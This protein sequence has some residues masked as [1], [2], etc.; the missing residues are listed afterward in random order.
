MYAT[1]PYDYKHNLFIYY[2]L[3]NL[4]SSGGGLRTCG[5]SRTS[6]EVVVLARIFRNSGAEVEVR[7]TQKQELDLV[8]FR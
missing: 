2:V 7:R 5:Q 3:A 1:T 4:I 8:Q 6:T